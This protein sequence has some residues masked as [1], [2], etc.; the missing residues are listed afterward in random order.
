MAINQNIKWSKID[1]NSGGNKDIFY[2]YNTEINWSKIEA[3]MAINY[4]IKQYKIEVN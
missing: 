2:A 3:N 1:I 4:G